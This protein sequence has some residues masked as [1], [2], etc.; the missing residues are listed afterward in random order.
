MPLMAERKPKSSGDKPK[1]PSRET[2]TSVTISKK[3]AKEMAAIGKKQDR[4]LAY[5]VRKACEAYR[6]AVNKPSQ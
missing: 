5:I 1:Y 3:L 4:S 6:D 2:Y